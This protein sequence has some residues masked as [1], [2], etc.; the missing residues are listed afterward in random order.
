MISRCRQDVTDVKFI[1]HAISKCLKKK[2][3]RQDVVKYLAQ[4]AGISAA[5]MRE[6]AKDFKNL[7]S[8]ILRIAEEMSMRIR[9][10][11]ISRYQ[12]RERMRRD[13]SS[14]KMRRIGLQCIEHQL[15]EYV[16][17]EGLLPMLR[18]RIGQF[19][20]ASYPKRGQVAGKK[21]IQTWIRQLPDRMRY[22]YKADIRHCY[23]SIDH[24]V[25]FRMLER[26]LEKN[27]TLLYLVKHLIQQF[28]RGLSIGSYL[29]QWMC[30][31]VMS[32][33]YHYMNSLTITTKRRGKTAREKMVEKIMFFMDDI[34]IFG[35]SEKLLKKA[36][37]LMRK[38]VKNV[39]YLEIKPAAVLEKFHYI[40][41][42]GER[43]GRLID[44]MGFRF[45]R[46]WVTIRRRNF[47]KI[48]RLFAKFRKKLKKKDRPR[49]DLLRAISSLW[50][51][52]ANS[53]S[54]R[55]RMIYNMDNLFSIVRKMLSERAKGRDYIPGRSEL[56]AK[57]IC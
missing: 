57:G 29:S 46:S 30:N 9:T 47:L 12:I 33:A 36:A 4:K 27:Q 48:R 8:T 45:Y 42:S 35:R 31:Y 28:R 7:S 55:I 1:F 49:D 37:E 19:Q 17:V 3:K 18:R 26:D 43:L 41:K 16:A 13:P 6:L 51:W 2:R 23:E 52:V 5:A 20:M 15:Y 14:G 25:I 21:T 39:L 53:D 50:G 44:F 40:K 38:F 11:T 54:M 10:Q 24:Q 34:V 22:F 56:R 32:K